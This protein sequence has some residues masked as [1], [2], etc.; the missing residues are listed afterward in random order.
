VKQPQFTQKLLQFEYYF[1][2]QL[3]CHSLFAVIFVTVMVACLGNL[4]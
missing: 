1:K 4:G 2:A 3:C